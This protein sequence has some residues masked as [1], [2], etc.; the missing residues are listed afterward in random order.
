MAATAEGY[1]IVQTGHLALAVPEPHGQA[2]PKRGRRPGL[3][4]SPV[5]HVPEG[6]ELHLLVVV[7]D[8]LRDEAEVGDLRGGPAELEDHD[9]RPVVEEGG[10]LRGTRPAAQARAEDEGEG[11][12]DTDGACGRT[13]SGAVTPRGLPTSPRLPGAG[14]GGDEP[15]PEKALAKSYSGV[16]VSR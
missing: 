7:G 14:P 1:A 12:Q 8:E 4:A 10:P 13:E 16:G 3:R 2:E 6:R 9:E 11:Q 5:P 15:G